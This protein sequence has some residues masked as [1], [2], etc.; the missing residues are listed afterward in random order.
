MTGPVSNHPGRQ[1][2]T[3]EERTGVDESIGKE[4]R[5]Q[6]RANTNGS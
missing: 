4:S 3:R 1:E 2:T 5:R 6:T